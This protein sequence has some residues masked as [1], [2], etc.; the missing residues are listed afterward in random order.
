MSAPA[1]TPE[2]LPAPPPP[3][4]PPAAAPRR[5]AA[6]LTGPLLTLAL[7][8][9]LAAVALGAQGGLQL[10]PLTTA[11]VALDV[12]AGALCVLAVLLAA[13]TRRPWG[14]VPLAAFGALAILTGVS[15]TWAIQ[16]AD[17]WIETNRTL[18]A[19]AVFAAGLALV[20]LAPDR[21]RALLGGVLLATVV[22]SGYALLTKVFPAALA[23]DE[24]Y[25]RLREPFEYWNAVG[26]MAA[27]GAPIAVWLGARRD[28]HAGL[29]ALAYPALG[30]LVVAIL[31]AYSRGALAAMALGLAVWFALVPL[32]LRGAVVLL[33]SLLLGALVA[34]WTFGQPGLSDDD[35]ALGLRSNAGTELGVLLG[36]LVALLLL[37]GF[38]L[39]WLR[40]RRAWPPATRRALAIALLAGLALVPVGVAAALATTERGL[41]GSISK[42][43]N[44]LTDPDANTPKNDPSRLTAIGSVRAR[45]WRDAIEI[46][47]AREATGVGAGGYATARVR[48]RE[49]DLDVLH[50]HGHLVQTAADLGIVGLAVTLALLAA[51]LAAAVRTTGPWRGPGARPATAERV[52]LLTLLAVVVAFGFHS[53]I[54]WT[55]FVPGTL[56]PALLCAAWVAG[57]GPSAERPAEAG[58]AGA[59]LRSRI[60]SPA[61]LLAV[62]LII[63]LAATAAWS[64][65]AP[66][67]ALDRVDE[68][69]AAL[70][71]GE[72][73]RARAL[74]LEAADTDPLSVE[75]LFARAE[76]ERTAR[77]IPAA[78]DALERAVQLQP[79]NAATWIALAR[80]DL[81]QGD[82]QAAMR[83]VQPALYLDR[84]S[85][86]AQAVYLQAFRD[87]QAAKRPPGERSASAG[88]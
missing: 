54:D 60:A 19:F 30:L 87:S 7:G 41:G 61:R 23:E 84:R 3:A 67:R 71:E 72:T 44:D 32:R 24:T 5:G 66:Q 26:L 27:L 74:A 38:A 20:R 6:R 21:W 57:R 77:A 1:A 48:F 15:V 10:G 18:S 28:G 16:P 36:V 51:W 2:A 69:L 14:A 73:E 25:A 35:V 79:A 68:A 53:L 62:A 13:P 43:W 86:A 39:T 29:A 56:A 42:A 80:F 63:G 83:D 45:Y 11:L 37:V 34:V 50:A 22:V 75:P 65:R 70:A 8:A 78:R 85:S 33:P 17:A 55:W 46:F 64:A 49:D 9:A 81:L 58:S 76:I 40:D 4:P 59:R 82:P 47:R 52:G 12:T 88:D 31:M